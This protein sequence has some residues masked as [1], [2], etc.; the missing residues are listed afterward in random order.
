ME[1]TK[2]IS[3][4]HKVNKI[5][6]YAVIAFL[7]FCLFILFDS[8]LL[9]R[10]DKQYVPLLWGRKPEWY[11]FHDGECK[12]YTN[13]EFKTCKLPSV[14]EYCDFTADNQVFETKKKCDLFKRYN[15]S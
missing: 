11:V 14:T 9:P 3:Q 7:I 6:F 10:N 2:N 12:L 4:K 8:F 15:E 1:A 13:K 5:V